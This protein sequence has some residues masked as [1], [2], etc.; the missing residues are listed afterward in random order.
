MST[1]ITSDR[2]YLELVS[3]GDTTI[4][5]TSNPA[6]DSDSHWLQTGHFIDGSSNY[7]NGQTIT[8]SIGSVPIVRVWFDSDKNGRLYNTMR[9]RGGD[10]FG[11]DIAIEDAPH[12]ISVSTTSTTKL[13][14]LAKSS[15]SN[16]PIHYRIYRFG[17]KGVTSDEQ[18]D[19]IFDSGS[20]NR[21]ISAAADSSIPTAATT[22]IA[23]GQ[24]EQILWKLQFSNNGTTWYDEGTPIYGAAD[25]SSGP[26]GGPYARYYNEIAYGSADSTNFYI[27]YI[28]NY[29]SSRTIYTR[30]VWEYK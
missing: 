3:F 8:H 27:T 25:T 12:V 21:T 22:T 30:W 16:I 7:G 11:V 18:I 1:S 20:H 13:L 5:A 28:H 15:T 19:K 9:F 26:P 23:H 29:P 2:D 14:T 4:N 6:S 24:G 10:A 17:T